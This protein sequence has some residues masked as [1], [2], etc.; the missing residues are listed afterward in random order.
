RPRVLRQ[1]AGRRRATED[2]ET[3]SITSCMPNRRLSSSTLKRDKS[4]WLSGLARMDPASLAV[5]TAAPVLSGLLL[6]WQAWLL[7]HALDLSIV[8]G[9][10]VTEVR[11]I[12]L[13]IVG[14]IALRAAI[15]WV[16]ERAACRG[17]ERIKMQLRQTL[18]STLLA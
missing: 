9:A 14:I 6:L 15:V 5:A 11:P 17:T 18:F 12:I 1:V 10:A 8:Q 7:S 3:R 13:T 2:T 16:G 4:G